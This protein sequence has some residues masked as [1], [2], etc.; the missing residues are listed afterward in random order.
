LQVWLRVVQVIPVTGWFFRSKAGKV[1]PV[2]AWCKDHDGR[3]YCMVAPT[4]GDFGHLAIHNGDVA[5][6]KPRCQK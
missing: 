6:R 4:S 1:I 5:P 3:A 2:T